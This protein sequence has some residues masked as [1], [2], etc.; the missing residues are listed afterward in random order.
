MEDRERRLST[1]QTSRGEASL[2]RVKISMAFFWRGL[3]SVVGD[4]LVRRNGP[5]VSLPDPLSPAQALM[6][7]LT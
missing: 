5:N 7:P 2:S 6:N 1:T 3:K 4:V